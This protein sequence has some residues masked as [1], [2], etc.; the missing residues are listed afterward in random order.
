M[1]E[2]E[3]THLLLQHKAM[4]GYIPVIVRNK[5]N[6]RI[7]FASGSVWVWNLVSDITGGI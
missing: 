1:V 3:S 4:W 5:N 2:T 7:N 6:R